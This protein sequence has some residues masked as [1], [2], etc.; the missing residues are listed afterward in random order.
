LPLTQVDCPGE[1]LKEWI[2]QGARTKEG[3]SQDCDICCGPWRTIRVWVAKRK[4]KEEQ[5]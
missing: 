3:L 4:L 2:T 1:A 5:N